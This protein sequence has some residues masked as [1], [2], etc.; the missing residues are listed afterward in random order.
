MSKVT[1]I[2]DY[3]DERNFAE[4]VELPDDKFASFYLE[5][6]RKYRK[7]GWWES[8]IPSCDECNVLI[9]SPKELRRY[10]G[11]SLH[12]QCFRAVHHRERDTEE[13]TMQ[14]YWDRVAQLDF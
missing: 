10:R 8:S 12:P 5:L 2:D 11:W 7:R 4:V 13:P 6:M 14:K 1:S 9:T 3:I